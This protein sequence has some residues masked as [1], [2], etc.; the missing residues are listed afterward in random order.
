MADPSSR[1]SKDAGHLDFDFYDRVV[2]LE[3]AGEGKEGSWDGSK[4]SCPSSMAYAVR[5]DQDRCY[6]YAPSELST[7]TRTLNSAVGH[8]QKVLCWDEAPSMQQGFINR[9]SSSRAVENM[10]EIGWCN[11]ITFLNRTVREQPL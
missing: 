4:C 1:P 3:R 2:N 5:D 8:G 7:R 11:Q 9:S 10:N 6:C